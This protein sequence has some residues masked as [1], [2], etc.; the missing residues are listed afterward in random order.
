LFILGMLM[1]LLSSPQ[2]PRQ[3]GGMGAVILIG[4]LPVVFGSSPEMAI[5]SM[6][7]ALMLM[8]LSY[9]LLRRRN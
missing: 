8:S 1:I 5:V 6:I 9:L 3:N 4:P 2:V 7:L